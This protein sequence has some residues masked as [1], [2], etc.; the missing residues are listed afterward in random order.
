MASEHKPLDGAGDIRPGELTV[1]DHI[2][3]AL[4]GALGCFQH[5]QALACE[6]GLSGWASEFEFHKAKSRESIEA[7]Q[8]WTEQN[9]VQKGGQ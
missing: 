1:L 3:I 7:F 2:D 5:A 9:A 6:A 8:S 4:R